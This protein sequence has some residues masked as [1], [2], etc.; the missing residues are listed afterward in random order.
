MDDNIMVG[1]IE[2]INDAITTLK[3]NGLILNIVEGL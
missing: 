1:D 2:A 3:N